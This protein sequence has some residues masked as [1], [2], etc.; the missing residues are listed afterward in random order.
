MDKV[1]K[2][3]W[4]LALLI[5]ITLVLPCALMPQI[6]S[7]YDRPGTW[8]TDSDFRKEDL[9]NFYAAFFTFL[10]TIILGIAAVFLSQQSN[11]MN[12]RLI[13]IEENNYIPFI[14]INCMMPVEFNEFSLKDV[15]SIN[16][17]DTFTDIGDDMDILVEGDSS[18]IVVS[19]TNVS[20]TDIINIEL[21]QMSLKAR[22]A[23]DLSS[24]LLYENLNVSL[25]NKVPCQATIPFIIGGIDIPDPPPE[26][27]DRENTYSNP[28]IGVA[29]EFQS[30]NFLGEIYVQKIKFDLIDLWANQ[31]NYPAVENKKNLGIFAA[32]S[33]K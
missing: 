24:P 2:R 1:N 16:L 33:S 3:W 15:F 31:I 23:P 13:N 11:E 27:K 9:L 6:L 17:D 25:N 30:T 10:G 18:V 12:R 28:V 32:H 21:Y 14:D 29:L 19:M 20:K 4:M 22:Y 5:V 7:H 26:I 8:L